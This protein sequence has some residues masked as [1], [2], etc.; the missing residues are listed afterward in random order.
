M[1]R[2]SKGLSQKSTSKDRRRRQAKKKR[3]Q[4]GDDDGFADFIRNRECSA[5]GRLPLLL[6]SEVAHILTRSAGHGV[7]TLDG[8]AN[9][10]PLCTWCHAKQHSLGWEKFRR[11]LCPPGWEKW[12]EAAAVRS[13]F[14]RAE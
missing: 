3:E 10:L 8:R 2:R 5:C 4:M 6:R 13:T 7:L 12:D 11:D 14:Y 1:P 9:V